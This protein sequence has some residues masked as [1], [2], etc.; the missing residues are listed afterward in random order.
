[1]FVVPESDREA[2]KALAEQ[3]EVLAAWLFGSRCRGY[4]HAGSDVDL[5]LLCCRPLSL[6]EHVQLQLRLMDIFDCDRIDLVQ[7]D[8]ETSPVLAFE[9]I[10]GRLLLSR[11]EQRRCA[12]VSQMSREYEEHQATLARFFQWQRE[13]AAGQL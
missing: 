3:P 2:S 6:D 10:S 7:L 11:D 8:E 13:L 12:Y 1:M 5:A 9:A 4:Q